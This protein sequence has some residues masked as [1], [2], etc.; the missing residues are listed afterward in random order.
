[1]IKI[2]TQEGFAMYEHLINPKYIV[3]IDE[4]RNGHTQ[5]TM[6]GGAI[7]YATQDMYKIYEQIQKTD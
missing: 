1:M 3:S 6:E 7:Y 2:A 5:I 4:L